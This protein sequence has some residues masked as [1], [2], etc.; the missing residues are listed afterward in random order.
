MNSLP[1]TVFTFQETT[2]HPVRSTMQNGEP[3]FVAAD[4]CAA[5]DIANVSDAVGRLEEYEK[6]VSL[7]TISG[8]GRN[9]LLVNESGIYSLVFTSR[10][11]EAKAFKKWVTTEVLPSI[12]KTGSYSIHRQLPERKLLGPCVT[13]ERPDLSVPEEMKLIKQYVQ[14]IWDTFDY[15]PTA[16]ELRNWL[17]R[18]DV[19]TIK[20]RLN[21]LVDRGELISFRTSH[22]VK[23]RP[24]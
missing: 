13:I 15:A 4:V 19:E 8:Q 2:D 6:L 1:S 9:V 22:A 17:K 11:P 20:T 12:R 7:V 3:W 5:L 21:D 23:Y 10:K 24:R 14:H 16:A 18:F